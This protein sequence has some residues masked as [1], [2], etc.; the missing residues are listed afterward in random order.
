MNN[1][2]KL[3]LLSKQAFIS[4]EKHSLK[5]FADQV[6]DV[7]KTAI[8]KGNNKKG[9]LNRLKNMFKGV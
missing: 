4:S 1:R 2:K 7:Y 6:L 5:H 3:G 8:R 9:I